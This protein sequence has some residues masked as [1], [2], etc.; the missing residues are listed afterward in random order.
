MGKWGGRSKWLY[1]YL[2]LTLRFFTGWAS[3][4]HSH[5]QLSKG[6]SQ[7]CSWWHLNFVLWSSL[8]NFEFAAKWVFAVAKDRIKVFFVILQI[9]TE[10][11]VQFSGFRGSSLLSL[12]DLVKNGLWVV[13][14]RN[15][16]E[17]TFWSNNL[18]LN[19]KSN[20]NQAYN[21]IFEA[22]L[23]KYYFKLISLDY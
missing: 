7:M 5:W 14:E 17:H 3:S 13:F 19:Y 4:K 1:N 21:R 11:W 16:L 6:L 22:R 8:S 12:T 15:F 2:D 23:N 9:L 18:N 10:N 20:C